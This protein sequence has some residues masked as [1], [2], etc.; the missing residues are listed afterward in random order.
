M[1]IGLWVLVSPWLLGFSGVEIAKWSNVL[2][3]LALIVINAWVVFEE[4]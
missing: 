4:K 3:G 2:L 1:F